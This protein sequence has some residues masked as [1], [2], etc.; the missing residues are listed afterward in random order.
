MKLLI[1]VHGVQHYKT[2]TWDKISAERKN[3]TQK[4][5]FQ[6]RKFYDEYKKDYALKNGYSYLEIPYWTEKDESYKKIIDDKINQI[7]KEVA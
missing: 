5:V 1:E 2:C 7:T 4:E 3:I 6:K